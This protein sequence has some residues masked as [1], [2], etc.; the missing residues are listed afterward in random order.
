MKHLR[1]VLGHKSVGKDTQQCIGGDANKRPIDDRVGRQIND[2]PH[3]RER[4]R[5]QRGDNALGKQHG[6]EKEQHRPK[7]QE[8]PDER[9]VLVSA[10][11]IDESQCL[12][13][14]QHHFP[15]VWAGT[16]D[17]AR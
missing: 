3:Y 17:R 8:L 16:V 11:V 6:E 1:M 14:M 12:D 5:Y 10:Q 7:I 2:W 15:G 13:R 9:D 4:Y